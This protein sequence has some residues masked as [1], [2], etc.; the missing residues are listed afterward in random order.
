MTHNKGKRVVPERFLRPLKD[1]IYTKMK[2]HNSHSYPDYLDKIVD[3]SS[4]TCHGSIG[5]KPIHADYSA[6]I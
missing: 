6:L 1:K 2:T 3:G 5:N 4:N